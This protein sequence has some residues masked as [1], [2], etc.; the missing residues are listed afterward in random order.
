MTITILYTSYPGMIST[1]TLATSAEQD[2]IISLADANT[3][4]IEAND[5]GTA[6]TVTNSM[7]KDE[8]LDYINVLQ[9]M[10]DQMS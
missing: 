1:V 8:L 2:F 6:D 3:I 7:T 9:K 5:S 10:A 4:D